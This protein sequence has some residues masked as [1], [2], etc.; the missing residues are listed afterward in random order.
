MARTSS[1]LRGPD[2]SKSDTGCSTPALDGSSLLD[3]KFLDISRDLSLATTPTAQAHQAGFF[4]IR[5]GAKHEVIAEPPAERTGL[6]FQSLPNLAEA[7]QTLLHAAL[8]V[9]CRMTTVTIHKSRGIGNPAEVWTSHPK[10]W[11]APT[12]QA[13]TLKCELKGLGIKID[14][15]RNPFVGTAWLGSCVS[16]WDGRVNALGGEGRGRGPCE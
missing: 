7:S 15:I 3:S 9:R 1:R 16:Q 10:V 4:C 8:P 12:N 13:G 6:A 2:S 11:V 14:L 5:L